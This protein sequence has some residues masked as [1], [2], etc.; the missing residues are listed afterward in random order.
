MQEDDIVYWQV[1]DA[2]VGRG[3]TYPI[4][5]GDAGIVLLREFVRE[6]SIFPGRHSSWFFVRNRRLSLPVGLG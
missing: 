3:H 2:V 4:N 5:S 1:G 6:G